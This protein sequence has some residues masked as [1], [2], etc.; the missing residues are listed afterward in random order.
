LKRVILKTPGGL[1]HL[2]LTEDDQ[3]EPRP[4]ELQA[5]TPN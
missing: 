2:Q 4:G 3:L 5:R 1:E